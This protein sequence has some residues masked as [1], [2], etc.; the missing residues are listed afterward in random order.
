MR[1]L[2]LLALCGKMSA[3][4]EAEALL[5]GFAAAFEELEDS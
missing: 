5:A 3:E 1:M 2:V 4:E